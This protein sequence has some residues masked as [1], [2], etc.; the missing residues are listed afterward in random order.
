MQNI[1]ILMVTTFTAEE[2]AL[3]ALPQVCLPHAEELF[4]VLTEGVTEI[5]EPSKIGEIINALDIVIEANDLKVSYAVEYPAEL[6]TYRFNRISSH[7]PEMTY[8]YLMA[9]STNT[10]FYVKHYEAMAEILVGSMRSFNIEHTENDIVN[11]FSRLV[12]HIKT[13]YDFSALHI[14]HIETKQ[15]ISIPEQDFKSITK[16]QLLSLF[17]AVAMTGY[18]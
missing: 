4:D 18:L 11:L 12:G 7:K 16:E 9:V 3:F 10:A 14:T 13:E 15:T 2:V 8:E 5:L 6:M 17:G 1:Q